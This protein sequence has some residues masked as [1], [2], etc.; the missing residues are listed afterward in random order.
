MLVYRAGVEPGRRR[1]CRHEACNVADENNIARQHRPPR[2]MLHDR[3]VVDSPTQ[4]PGSEPLLQ[5]DKVV[6]ATIGH[7]SDVRSFRQA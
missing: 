1:P 2:D 4:L 5:T 6:T 7:K 3:S